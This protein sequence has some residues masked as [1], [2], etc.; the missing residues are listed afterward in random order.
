LQD[1]GDPDGA[2]A[3]YRK[4]VALRPRHAEAHNN[5]GLLLRRRGDLDEAVDA[6]RRATAF[7]PALA[8]AHYNLGLALA[9]RKAWGDA[10]DAF[11]ESLRLRP[12]H[13]PSQDQLLKIV[14]LWVGAWSDADNPNARNPSKGQKLAE[15]L[16]E[17]SPK[18][19]P[20]WGALGAA[21]YRAGDA[22]AAADA[23]NTACQLGQGG[24]AVLWFL[25]A[26]A[27]DRL[28]DKDRARDWFDR[29]ARWTD[30]HA[31]N[32][33]TLRRLRAEAAALL[34]V[35]GGAKPPPDGKQPER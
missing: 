20:Y 34:R 9:A 2:I 5:L 15:R 12:D 29:A 28:G 16:V 31:P 32:H 14:G 22:K 23:L 24:D 3:A 6:F 17:L 19:A 10:A 25:L 1:A 18:H 26:M 33:E 8:A 21:R 30:E 27:H 13:R 4:A 11:F 7:A 35:A